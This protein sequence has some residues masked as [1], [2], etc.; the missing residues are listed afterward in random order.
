MEK[1]IDLE[2]L[3]KIEIDILDYLDDV[4]KKNGIKYFLTGG[5]LLGA[6]RHKGFIPWDDDI[7]VMLL[8]EDYNKLM[9]V[10]QY[11]NGKYGVISGEN[12]DEYFYLFNKLVDNETVL[13]EEDVPY[14]K[15]YGVYIDLFPL[16]YLP[17]DPSERKKTQRSILLKRRCLA[18]ALKAKPCQETLP[19][20]IL[21]DC[22]SVIGW[23]YFR[24]RLQKQCDELNKA[25][26]EY[27]DCV[28]AAD[29]QYRTIKKEWFDECTY[30]MFEGK[31]Y[32]A[33]KYYHEYLAKLY[34]NYMELPPANKRISHHH[35][36]ANYK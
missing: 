8:R 33:P 1:N 9:K 36:V 14:I 12:N 18:Y 2:Q 19:K 23:R 5:T 35:F 16:D 6:V 21:S 34:G 22:L 32:P 17:N 11:N 3:K 4:C 7:D 29:N 25:T 27:I 10:L 24:D 30:L 13:T 26:T 31:E 15:N 20:K 28:V